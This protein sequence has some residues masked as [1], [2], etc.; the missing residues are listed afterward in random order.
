MLDFFKKTNNVDVS[1]KVLACSKPFL[2]FPETKIFYTHFQGDFNLV[3]FFSIL[4]I[5][6]QICL[7]FKVE[8]EKENLKKEEES[9]VSKSNCNPP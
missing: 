9:G 3:D 8:R 6:G 7:D 1:Q 2:G 4:S 5:I